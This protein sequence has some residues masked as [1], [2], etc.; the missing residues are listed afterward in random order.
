MIER[1]TR[2]NDVDEDRTSTAQHVP[3]ALLALQQR[4]KAESAAL[5][6]ERTQGVDIEWVAGALEQRR[7][8]I[9]LRGSS[10]V[11]TEEQWQTSDFY[12]G[13]DP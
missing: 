5:V 4:M 12:S 11:D 8:L 7:K 9:K 2:K 1:G 6:K 3:V 10:Q 13:R